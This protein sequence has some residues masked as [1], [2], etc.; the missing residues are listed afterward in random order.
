MYDNSEEWLKGRRAWQE[1][2]RALLLERP[3]QAEFEARLLAISI[4]PNYVDSPEYRAKVEANQRIVLAL[5]ADIIA[6]LDAKQLDRLQ[7]RLN[8]FARDF[9]ALAAE[10]S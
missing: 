8:G 7:R 3:P 6:S 9:D 10:P 2:F 5:M 1:D 4:D